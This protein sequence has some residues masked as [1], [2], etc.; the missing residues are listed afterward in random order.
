MRGKISGQ[1]PQG[2]AQASAQICALLEE[3]SRAQHEKLERVAIF[4]AGPREPNLDG[5]GRYLQKAGVEVFAP[6]MANSRA[7]F[8]LIAPDWSN[9]AKNNLGWREPCSGVGGSS[10]QASALDAIFLP[11]LA[12]DLKGNRLGQG[13][14]WYDRA[15]EQLSPQVICAGVGFDFQIVDAL[16]H[17]PHDRNVSLIVT[18]KR[19]AYVR[20]YR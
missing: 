11:G 5:F 2:Q 3:W 16:P 12:F 1:S 7:P 9:V 4:L 20:K 8:A 15:L 18:E 13:G 14:G 17:E 10:L 19:I 6:S